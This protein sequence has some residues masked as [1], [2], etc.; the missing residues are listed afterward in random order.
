MANKNDNY[1][2]INGNEFES[3]CLY[4]PY[5][6]TYVKNVKDIS[7]MDIATIELGTGIREALIECNPLVQLNN[8]N[9]IGKYPYAKGIKIF[10]PILISKETEESKRIVDRFR[11]LAEER[12]YDYYHGNKL[13]LNEDKAKAMIESIMSKLTSSQK[14]TIF[15]KESIIGKNIKSF[16][17]DN[18]YRFEEQLSNYTQLRNLL[19]NYLAVKSGIQIPTNQRLANMANSI[20]NIKELY[21]E[22]PKVIKE[23]L[24]LYKIEIQK[25]KEE[26][27]RKKAEQEYNSHKQ[28]HQITLFDLT[29]D[30]SLK[31]LDKK[32]KN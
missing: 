21:P 24:E 5:N 28:Y 1:Y 3:T 7:D 14:S 30:E 17:Y 8:T 4:V 2:F 23:A 16:R 32:R 10:K 6:G 26:E 13:I 11:D 9:Y 12:N 20:D 31:V 27:E 25:A 22:D 15:S 29:G 19:I 18:K